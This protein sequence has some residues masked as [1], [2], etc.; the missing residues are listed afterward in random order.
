MIL[1]PNGG[2]DAEAQTARL[3]AFLADRERP[4]A[5][6]L[7]KPLDMLHRRT[8]SI[9]HGQHHSAHLFLAADKAGL[10][11]SGQGVDFGRRFACQIAPAIAEI[12]HGLSFR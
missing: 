8:A 1:A 2:D 7:A 3:A 5:E 4:L 10:P 11:S 12:K 9:G 6:I